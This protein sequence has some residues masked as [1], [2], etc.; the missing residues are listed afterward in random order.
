MIKGLK[1]LALV[2]MGII[3]ADK[4]MGRILYFLD[5]EFKRYVD[6]KSKKERASAG[7]NVVIKLSGLNGHYQTVKGV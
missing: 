7:E 3:T 2:V 5:P 4:L 6:A 1:I